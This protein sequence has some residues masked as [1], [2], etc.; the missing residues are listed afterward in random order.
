MRHTVA[1]YFFMLALLCIGLAWYSSI[2][3]NQFSPAFLQKTKQVMDAADIRPQNKMQV[4]IIKIIDG[5]TIETDN[6]QKI[7]YIGINA[8]ELGQ[9]YGED[10]KNFNDNLVNGKTVT[11]IFDQ[12]TKDQYGR[13]LG[14]IYVENIFVNKVLVE[15]G[16]A[17]S[18]AIPPNTLH[19]EDFLQAEKQAHQ[20]CQGLWADTCM[21]KVVSCIKIVTIHFDAAGIDDINLNDEWI[22]ITSSCPNVLSLS[23]WLLKDSS[24]QNNYVFSDI[25]LDPGKS[26]K[27]HSGCGT[28]SVSDI[29]WQCP[30]KQHAI[31]NNTGDEAMLF[32]SHGKLLSDYSY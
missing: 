16:W 21:P 19:K 28:N 10:A 4:K 31:W 29:Y 6:H 17:I 7:R 27:L 11:I 3:P 9:P 25:S 24:A 32:D 13:M 2:H 15:K 8:P 20:K 30:Q 5:D 18:E 22:E 1:G 14:Y 26:L 23:G 12:Q